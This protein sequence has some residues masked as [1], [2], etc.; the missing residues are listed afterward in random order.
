MCIR[1][2][3]LVLVVGGGKPMIMDN[4]S[5]FAN[6]VVIGNITIGDNVKIGA[7]SVVTKTVPND[8]V[9]VGNPAYIIRKNGEKVS[10]KL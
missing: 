5:I 1:M 10:I 6:S 7:G 9:V 2:L 8:C 3:Q 4:V